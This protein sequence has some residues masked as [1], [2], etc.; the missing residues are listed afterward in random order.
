VLYGDYIF[1]KA[2]EWAGQVEDWR[3]AIE[4]RAENRMECMREMELFV[5]DVEA[6]FKANLSD[7]PTTL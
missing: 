7:T 4:E 1:W 5:R 2:S 6:L 3:L